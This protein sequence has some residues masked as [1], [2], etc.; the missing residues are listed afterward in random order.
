[1]EK[2]IEKHSL[3]RSIILHLLPGILG[4]LFY[5]AIIPLVNAWGY[6]SLMALIISILVIGPFELGIVLF[7]KRQTGE[8]LFSGVIR[9]CQRIPVW[10][11][12]VF[13]PL[14]ILLGALAF[15]LFGFIGDSLRPLFSWL[16]SLDMGLSNEYSKN[17][18]IFTYSLFFIFI[19]VI[20]PTIEEIYFR[21]YLLPRMPD[22]LKGWTPLVHTALF[23][24]Y[25]IW[26]PWMFV[27][28][29]MGVLPLTYIVKYKKNILIGIIAHVLLN[30]V[31]F[32]TGMIFI[33]SLS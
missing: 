1:M 28:R 26:T 14:I 32:I 8:K 30:T 5:F 13:I 19:V 4:G 33:F 29:I 27:A 22:K 31:D 15:T 7:H 23:S 9:Y 18:L 25:H 6:P 11:Y 16:P 21:G 12:F 2:S 24:L 20:G 3:L 10:Q 17:A